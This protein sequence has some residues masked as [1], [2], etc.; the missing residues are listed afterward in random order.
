MHSIP[1]FHDPVMHPVK[2][3]EEKVLNDKKIF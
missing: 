1:K 2:N 3:D